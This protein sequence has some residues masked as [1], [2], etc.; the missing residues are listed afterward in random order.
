VVA[1]SNATGLV[2]YVNTFDEYG[3]GGGA[4][5]FRFGFAGQVRLAGNLHYMRSRIYSADLGRFVQPDPIGYGDGMNLYAYVG[6]DP[7]NFTDPFGLT[8]EEDEDYHDIVVNGTRPGGSVGGV[9]LGY[10]GGGTGGRAP[11]DPGADDGVFHDIIVTARKPR[12]DRDRPPPIG[13]NKPP[14]PIWRL[15]TRAGSLLTAILS[16]SGDRC[17]K[18]ELTIRGVLNNPHLL[19]NL[20]LSEVQ[21]ALSAEKGWVATSGVKGAHKNEV[22]AL[23]ERGARD[24]TG[25]QIRWHPGGGHHGPN[26]Y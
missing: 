18:C 22:W 25:R 19:E 10:G 23:R 20:T 9:I 3:R 1:G 8:R 14:S 2:Q 16:L 17:V 21:S 5:A 13:H 26:P 15:L 7:V 24:W 6:G 11:D 4:N 12:P